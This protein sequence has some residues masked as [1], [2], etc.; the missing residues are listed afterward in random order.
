MTH[1]GGRERCSQQGRP[2][3]SSSRSSCST[4]G[5]PARSSGR[6]SAAAPTRV[7]V[8]LVREPVNTEFALG[9]NVALI[10]SHRLRA[11]PQQRHRGARRVAR[12]AARRARRSPT[13]SRCQPL[14][15]Y[16]DGIVQCAGRRVPASVL[17]SRSTSCA[18]HPPEDARPL[19]TVATHALTAAAFAVRLRD[20]VRPCAGS[21]RCSPTGWEDIDLFLRAGGGREPLLPRRHGVGR[22]PPREQD[23]GPRRCARRRTASSSSTAGAELPERT[24]NRCGTRPASRSGALRAGREVSADPP[25][26]RTAARASDGPARPLRAAARPAVTAVGDQE[27]GPPAGPRGDR[28][29]TSTS[30]TRS[31]ES[32][33]GSGRRSSS[34][35]SEAHER[36]TSYLDDIAL[37]PA[38]AR[39]DFRPVQPGR[40][41]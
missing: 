41:N 15:L 38:R 24:P 9:S 11:V 26:G 6:C 1:P 29:A 5:A 4:T 32:L 16:P 12:A 10:E 3:P 27:R 19:G 33:G 14:L 23:P 39:A 22:R 36:S 40:L 13:S 7:H 37:E 30:P 18:D 8:R 28:G 35:T 2:G 17:A 31:R 25:A 20:V 21:T 34:T